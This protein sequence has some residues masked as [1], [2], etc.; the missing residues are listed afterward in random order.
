MNK[1][2]SMIR[3]AAGWFSRNIDGGTILLY[4]SEIYVL[5]LVFLHYENALSRPRQQHW[6]GSRTARAVLMQEFYA[7]APTSAPAATKTGQQSPLEVSSTYI[8]CNSLYLIGILSCASLSVPFALSSRD[9]AV[10]GR[11]IPMD[12]GT[13]SSRKYIRNDARKYCT[14]HETFLGWP[15]AVQLQGSRRFVQGIGAARRRWHPRIFGSTPA[16]ASATPAD[17]RVC[18]A[19]CDGPPI[20]LYHVRRGAGEHVAAAAVLTALVVINNSTTAQEA[21]RRR[22]TSESRSR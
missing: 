11:S 10:K 9:P 8:D 20:T 16:T 6:L 15:V 19:P 12:W 7:C 5:L 3:V 22:G 13:L 18:L 2:L 14:F 21:Y 4:Y 1:N 17:G